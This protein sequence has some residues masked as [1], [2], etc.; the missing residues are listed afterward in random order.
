MAVVYEDLAGMDGSFENGGGTME[1]IYFAPISDFETIVAPPAIGTGPTLSDDIKITGP[2]VMKTGKKLLSMN[3]NYD[4]GQL[5]A[6][7]SG[8]IGGRSVAPSF[9]CQYIGLTAQVLALQRAVKNDRYLFFIPLADG[10]VCQI[11]T[12]MR[13]ARAAIDFDSGKAQEGL[14]AGTLTVTSVDNAV[15]VYTG[16]LPLTEAV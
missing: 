4:S 14:K 13:P 3:V 6:A 2:H 7:V 1:T 8:E 15:W 11:G 16:D 9:V 5:T 10:T 12:E